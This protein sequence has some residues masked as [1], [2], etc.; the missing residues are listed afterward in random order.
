MSPARIPPS[1]RLL[2][3]TVVVGALATG[4][5]AAGAIVD[6]AEE[7]EV[8][9]SSGNAVKAL[10]SVEAAF[11]AVWD[12]APLGFSEALFVSGK[13]EGFGI[14]EARTGNVFKAGEDMLVYAEP[15]GFGYGEDGEG[16]RITFDA[17]YELRNA[18]GQIMTAQS[19]FAVLDT[20]TRRRNKEFQVFVTYSFAGLKP[21]DYVLVTTLR[22]RN[23]D[24]KGSFELPFTIAAP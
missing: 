9:L 7:A 12:R 21:G 17:D 18:R 4:S 1:V 20:A 15:F 6:R 2:A 19:G 16:F 10:A 24:K 8:Q 22:D 23:S 14:Y 13:P 3:A 5:A 11:N